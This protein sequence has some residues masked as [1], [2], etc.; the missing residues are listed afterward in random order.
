M[1]VIYEIISTTV[2]FFC[3]VSYF[4]GFIFNIG[5]LGQRKY[6]NSVAD[7]QELRPLFI[8]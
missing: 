8:Y 5:L 1:I 3:P 7:V 2:L 6:I 4:F